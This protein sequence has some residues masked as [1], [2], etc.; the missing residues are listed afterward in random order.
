MPFSAGGLP[1]IFCDG[2]R[3]PDDVV[4]DLWGG[5]LPA[6]ELIKFSVETILML[7]PRLSR[8]LL[9][10]SRVNFVS[11]HVCSIVP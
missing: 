11:A 10:L 8:S 1:E 6:E 2:I 7:L 3:N 9:D 4:S 5:I